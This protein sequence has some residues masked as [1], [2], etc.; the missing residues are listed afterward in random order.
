MLEIVKYKKIPF[1]VSGI[2]FLTSV[3][4]LVTLG[5][6]P[7]IDF[8]GGSLMEISFVQDRPAIT[9]VEEAIT[10]LAL[11]NV[12]VQPVDAD[13]YLIRMQFLS[14]NEH[15]QVLSSLR[16][17]FPL[18]VEGVEPTMIQENVELEVISG[19]EFNV[20]EKR[21]ETIGPS[22]STQ[23]KSRAW[24]IGFTVVFAI[25]FFIA[26]AFRKVSRPVSSWKFGITAIIA[27]IHDVTITMGV[28]ALLGHYAGVEVNIPFVVA[29][30]TILGYSVND[31]IVVFDR[32]RENL[33]KKGAGK[34]EACVV[35]GVNE[36]LVRSLNTSATTLLVLISL[37]LFGGLSIKYFAL[38][39]I[40][41]AIVGT[42][43]SIFLASPLLVVWER[44][45]RGK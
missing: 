33:M 13:G 35:K 15:Q 28:F 12:Q 2:V 18:V 29:L 31:T 1:V 17:A 43:S 20:I 7:G 32:I 14:E 42:Y 8:T 21:V 10:P 19:T 16:D 24:Q 3:F 44:M 22:I 27:L 38:A 23:L 6:K 26:Y 37:F 11:G 34:F 41:G 4:L 30:L 36:T 40:V 25:I 9:E 5:L 39:L 45:G